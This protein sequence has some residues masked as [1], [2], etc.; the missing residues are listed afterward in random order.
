MNIVENI[1]AE[2]IFSFAEIFPNVVYFRWV[3]TRLE[4]GK[5]QIDSI[6]QKGNRADSDETV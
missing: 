4:V 5:K 2:A 1:V 3:K 6:K